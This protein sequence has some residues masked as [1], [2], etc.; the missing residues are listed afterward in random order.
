MLGWTGEKKDAVILAGLLKDP[1]RAVRQDA[2]SAYEQLFHRL[3]KA[4]D[5]LISNL[6]AALAAEND[7]SVLSTIVLGLQTMLKKRFG[8]RWDYDEGVV[9]GD[10]PKAVQKARKALLSEP[11]GP[12]R[13][14]PD[15][16]RGRG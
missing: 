4:R 2:A 11:S 14:G 7:E 1:E 3:P 13:P 15:R 16:R 5:V 12:A 6:T 8:I 10:V 9:A